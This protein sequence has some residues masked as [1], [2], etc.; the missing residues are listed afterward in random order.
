MRKTQLVRDRLHRDAGKAGVSAGW[1]LVACLT[2]VL[3]TAARSN[4]AA[5]SRLGCA[6]RGIS[7][8]PRQS[9]HTRARRAGAAAVLGPD[10]VGPER[11]RVRDVPP[12]RFGYSDGLD[13]S[14][15]AN[16]AGLGHGEAFVAG[17]PPRLVKRNSQTVLNVAFNG[18][19]ADGGPALRRRRCSGI[20][21]CGASKRR[22]WSRSR[23]WRKCAAT[24]LRED[25]AVAA[26]VVAAERHSRVPPTVCSRVRES[27]LRRAQ[28]RPV[29]ERNLGRAL[30]AFQRTLVAVQYAV[31]PL[32][33]RR[34]GRAQPRAGSRHGAVPVGRLH[35]LPQRADVLGLR[36]ARPCRAGQPEAAR[37][38]IQA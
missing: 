25:R 19:T 23:R 2:A 3:A 4:T 11:R 37:N 29:N 34:H 20:C 35:Q 7:C 27:S 33:A 12:S 8:A 5:Q 32:H 31:R 9:V 18:L 26:A 1:V 15:G 10:P 30:A 28:G 36:R 16:G 6:S 24:R 21:G 22:R 14:I 13:L 17:H 38:R